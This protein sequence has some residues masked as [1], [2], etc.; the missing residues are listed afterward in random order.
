ME[1]EAKIRDFIE[2]KCEDYFLGT[3]DLSLVENSLTEDYSSLL[4]EYPR[5]ISIGVTMPPTIPSESGDA[6]KTVYTKVKCQLK[7][8]TSYLSSLL[9]YEG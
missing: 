8:I 2:A 1:F 5:A 9:E 4:K 3:V 7:S 6:K